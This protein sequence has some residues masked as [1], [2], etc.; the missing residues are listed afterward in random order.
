MGEAPKVE[1]EENGHKY[2]MGYYIVHNMYIPPC[3]MGNICQANSQPT[4]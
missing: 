2:N 4:W 3:T 1:F